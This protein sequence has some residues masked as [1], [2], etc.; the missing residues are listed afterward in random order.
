MT[1][2]ERIARLDV[3]L[4]R[5]TGIPVPVLRA[6]RQVE[7]G[8]NP[9][10]VRFETRVFRNRTGQTVEGSNRAAF[11]RAYAINPLEAVNST[12]WGW[13]QV[14]GFHGFPSM[15]GG[16]AQAVRAFDADPEGVSIA[17]F[18]RWMSRPAATRAKAAASRLDFATFASVYNGCAMPCERYSTRMRAAYERALRE[19][20]EYLR[21]RP[22]GSIALFAVL[23]GIVG[24]VGV[25]FYK[26]KKRTG[27]IGSLGETKDE[28][29]FERNLRMMRDRFMLAGSE[30]WQLAREKAK[31]AEDAASECHSEPWNA[32]QALEEFSAAL[33]NYAMADAYDGL[34]KG[35]TEMSH[36]GIPAQIQKEIALFGESLALAMS[37]CKR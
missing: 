7:S 13:F 16:P 5:D 11:Q 14:M 25:Y 1:P 20:E 28:E 12:S 17:L 8:G 4:A 2:T 35:R 24:G 19:W 32:K 10:A 21:N 23:F 27:Y 34:L 9:R 6:I 37:Y 31:M 30:K 18:K 36:R 26:R 29:Q 3:L 22:V 33:Q 15:Y